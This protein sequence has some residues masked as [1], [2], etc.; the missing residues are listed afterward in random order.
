MPETLKSL[1]E[2]HPEWANHPLVVGRADG[3]LD[4]IGDSGDIFELEHPDSETG[5]VLVVTEN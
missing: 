4:W 5:K 2:K 1:L 3:S